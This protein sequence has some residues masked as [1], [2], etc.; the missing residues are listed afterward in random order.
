LCRLSEYTRFGSS[1][2]PPCWGEIG[3]SAPGRGH[4]GVSAGARLVDLRQV[5]L[6]QPE[7]LWGHLQELVLSQEV[8]G[9]LEAQLAR[10]GQPD[11]DVRGR[12]PDVGLLLFTTDV[13]ADV[14]GPFLDPN[15]HPLVH[16]LARLDE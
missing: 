11:R 8:E 9:L 10:R 3:G 12:R 13:D 7:M 2:F 14:P 6:P 15:D 4:Q 16:G 1:P 5:A